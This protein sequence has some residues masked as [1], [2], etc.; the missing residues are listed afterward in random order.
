MHVFSLHSTA[1][2]AC[3][4]PFKERQLLRT[5]VAEERRVRLDEQFAS[6]ARLRSKCFAFW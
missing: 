6:H 1:V 5:V 3:R 2:V 4:L